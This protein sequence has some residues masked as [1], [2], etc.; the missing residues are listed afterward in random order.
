M[1]SVY[2]ETY[3]LLATIYGGILIGFIYDLYKVFRGIFNPKKLATNL[4]DI[5]F[6][7]IITIVA[8]YVLI[9]SNK[10]DLRFYN[11]LGFVIGVGIYYYLLSKKII[12]AL[13]FLVRLLKQFIRDLWKLITYPFHVGIC[14][15]SV[16]YSY[17]KMRSKPVYYKAKRI[18]KLPSRVVAD[19]KK[20]MIH[21]FKKK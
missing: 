7:T 15:I 14:L 21:Y 4:Q 2:H 9:F 12:Q 11:F 6:W 10:G 19:C 8:F 17:C 1:Y 20:S 5:F 18:I 3:I 16:P 13:T